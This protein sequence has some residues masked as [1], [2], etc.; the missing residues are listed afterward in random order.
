MSTRWRSYQPLREKKMSR[1]IAETFTH[2][3]DRGGKAFIPFI[4]SGDPDLGMTVRLVP[5]LERSGAHIVEL[6]IPFSDPLADGPTIQRS[7][8]R[9]LRH[10][11]HLSDH[12]DAVRKIRK[13]TAIPIVLFSYFNP[14][15]QYGLEALA[16]DAQSAGCDGI[17]VTDMTPEESREYCACFEMHELDTIFLAAPTSSPERV[18]KIADCSRGFVYI[19]SRAGVTGAQDQLSEALLP[20][21]SRVRLNTQLPIAV[22]FGISRPEQVR[23][24]WEVSDGAV[25]GSAI[26]AQMEKFAA[27][28]ELPAHVGEF[29]RW[30]MEGG[31]G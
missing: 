29:C 24:V 21:I 10:G 28:S 8:E 11:Y 12:L 7:S 16:R 3:R 2:L 18:K 4:T 26:I 15:F 13:Q 23:A 6:G 19:V 27:A 14:I 9:A 25:V 22:G 31:N 20:T 1:A 30:L 5:E 17:L